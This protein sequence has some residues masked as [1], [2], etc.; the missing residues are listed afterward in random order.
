MKNSE[1]NPSI[2]CSVCGRWMR[3]HGK[4]EDGAA[5]QRFYSCCGENGEYEHENPVCDECCKNGCP[6]NLK[7]V[8]VI[9]NEYKIAPDIIPKG[10]WTARLNGEVYDYHKKEVLIKKAKENGLK[11][12]IK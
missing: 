10:W 11:Y 1:R 6:Y 9:T 12:I 8:L 4:S 7:D 3:L 5:I 2:Q